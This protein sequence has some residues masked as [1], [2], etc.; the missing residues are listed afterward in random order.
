[1]TEAAA[2][3]APAA[4]LGDEKDAI[5]A[6]RF[7]KSLRGADGRVGRQHRRKRTGERQLVTVRRVVSRI[8]GPPRAG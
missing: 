1:M 8:F 7:L 2:G 5:A 6:R 4:A 3:P